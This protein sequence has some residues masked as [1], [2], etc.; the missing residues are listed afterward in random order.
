MQDSRLPI[1]I[2][3]LLAV[4]L[5]ARRWIRDRPA[6]ERSPRL[7]WRLAAAAACFT[8][9]LTTFVWGGLRAPALVDDE[10]AYLLQADLLAHG[11]WRLPSPEPSASFTQSPSLSRRSWRRKCHPVTRWCWLRA[12]SSASPG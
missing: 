10:A 9:V 2:V 6:V 12:C 5:V 3:L 11:K 1:L 4:V 8:I 7:Q